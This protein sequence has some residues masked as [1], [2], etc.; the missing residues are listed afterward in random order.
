MCDLRIAARRARFGQGFVNLGLIPG[1]GGAWF[2]TRAVPRHI[3]ADLIFSGRMVGAEEAQQMGLVNEVVDD[4]QLLPRA[5]EI[6]ATIA[7]KPPLAL[8]M[9]KRLLNKAYEQSLPDFLDTC[10]SYQSLLHRTADHREALAA[11]F[12]KRPGKYQGQ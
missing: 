4:E 11:F 12:E 3:A 8:K 2:L 9:S 6:A 7:S 1:D 5:R 10:A